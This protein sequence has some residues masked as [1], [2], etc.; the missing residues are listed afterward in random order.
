MVDSR[1]AETSS[2]RFL[3]H[4]AGRA[5]CESCLAIHTG[6]TLPQAAAAVAALGRLSEFAVG[7]ARCGSCGRTNTLICATTT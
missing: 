4:N 7:S 5:F 1:L 3:R 2:D 6:L